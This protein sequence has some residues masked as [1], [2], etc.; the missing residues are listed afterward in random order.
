MKIDQLKKD[1]VVTFD[2]NDKVRV[3]SRF[4][5][6]GRKYV[7][8]HEIVRKGST[9]PGKYKIME[10]HVEDGTLE[11]V[12][13]PTLLEIIF[14]IAKETYEGKK[15]EASRK[16]NDPAVIDD[17]TYGYFYNLI[18]RLIVWMRKE[19]YCSLEILGINVTKD[20]E[21]SDEYIK[22]I[23]IGGYLNDSE[24]DI[25]MFLNIPNRNPID[26]KF[27]DEVFDWFKVGKPR[28]ESLYEIYQNI[29]NFRSDEELCRAM[30]FLQS[31]VREKYP[32][33]NIYFSIPNS[34]TTTGYSGCYIA[35]AVYGSY[36]CAEV[37]TLRRFRDDYLS[38]RIWGRCFIKAY[39]HISPK[40]VD[41]FGD[42]KV[43]T[44]IFK[45][46]LDK[47]VERLNR[48]GIENTYYEDH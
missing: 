6:N 31:D 5:Y 11:K 47:M 40:L 16:N 26:K 17:F 33:A 24:R 7:Y 27:S 30:T 23:H 25:D 38:K 22:K 15:K 13:D 43:F 48:K 29:G 10:I 32:D 8:V 4:D 21:G 36:D 1:D 35:T 3:L 44:K 46:P 34:S 37:W 12:I 18:D 45:K 2:D 20:Y 9:D 19:E 41:V 14:P 42:S 39:Y 28:P